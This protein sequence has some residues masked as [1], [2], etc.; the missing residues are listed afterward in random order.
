MATIKSTNDALYLKRFPSNP[1]EPYG[2]V[3]EQ[4]GFFFSKGIKFGRSATDRYS[5]EEYFHPNEVAWRGSDGKVKVYVRS[6]GSIKLPGAELELVPEYAPFWNVNR[7]NYTGC[8]GS[9]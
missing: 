6:Q 1:E 9:T 2:Q 8:S 5:E 3:T 7:S 4:L